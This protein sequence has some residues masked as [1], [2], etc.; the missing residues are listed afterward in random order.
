[1]V[2]AKFLQF[3]RQWEITH[4]SSQLELSFLYLIPI[5]N[6][7]YNP[8]FL[9]IALRVV[10]SYGVHNNAF[11]DRQMDGFHDDSYIP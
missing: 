4:G 3:L 6:A 5:P 8:S 1:M 11:M 2:R 10:R 9:K 7:L